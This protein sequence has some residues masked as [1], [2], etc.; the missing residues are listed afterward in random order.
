MQNEKP[1][2]CKDIA[3]VYKDV[4]SIKVN[5]ND[6]F[7]DLLEKF[8]KVMRKHGIKQGTWT[9]NGSRLSSNGEWCMCYQVFRVRVDSEWMWFTLLNEPPKDLLAYGKRPKVN[10][11]QD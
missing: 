1:Q 5:I 6:S 11:T 4:N 2:I 10:T 7:K 3:A 9:E 8:Y